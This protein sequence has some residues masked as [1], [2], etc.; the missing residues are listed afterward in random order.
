M[1]R[2]DARDAG[3]APAELQREGEE[4]WEAEGFPAF[5]SNSHWGGLHSTASACAGHRHLSSLCFSFYKEIIQV[6]KSTS[7]THDFTI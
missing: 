5:L 4:G 2:F 3:A 6:L 1:N 7:E